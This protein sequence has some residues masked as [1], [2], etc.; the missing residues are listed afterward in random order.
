M[1]Q[2]DGRVPEGQFVILG[3]IPKSAYHFSLKISYPTAEQI[4][5]AAARGLDLGGD[6]MIH[7]LPNGE[8]CGTIPLGHG[9]DG[10]LYRAHR[11]GE[12]ERLWQTV[13][14]GTPI[15]ILP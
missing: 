8:L 6:I 11:S 9:L 2:G 15:S 5:A 1:Q 14:D 12:I 3:R 13:P 4:R 7:G 10:R